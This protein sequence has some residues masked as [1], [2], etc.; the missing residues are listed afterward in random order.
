MNTQRLTENVSLRPVTLNDATVLKELMHQIYPPPYKH[1]WEDNGYWYV[2]QTFN[3][4]VLEKELADLNSSYYFVE[5]KNETVGILRIVYDVTLSDKSDLK[6]TKLH[7]IYL[8]PKLQGKGLGKLLMD[9]SKQQAIKS[10]SK[11]IWLEAMDT[12]E[13]A[14][15]FYKK[16]GY[17]ISSDFKLTFKSM[18]EHLRGMHT[19]YKTL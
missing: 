8:D 4:T 12:Q 9:W 17:T 2:E 5:Y 6:A 14:L 1:L 11:I 13:Q 16:L 3:T 15:Q 18:H 19:M 7:R 10:G